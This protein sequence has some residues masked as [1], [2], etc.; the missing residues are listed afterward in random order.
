MAI[1]SDSHLFVDLDGTLIRTDLLFESLLR[2]IRRNPL[3]LLLLPLWL[4]RGRASLKR[5]LARRIALDPAAL[6]YHTE[7]LAW[8]REEHGRGRRMTLITA[9][10]QAHADAVGGHLGLF[11]AALGCG[12][13]GKSP[14]ANLPMQEIPA[15]IFPSG[16]R[17]ARQF[18]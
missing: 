13:F 17:Q 5:Q 18:L 3:Y 15:P 2:L 6:P 7:L 9:S 4:L 8:L 10:D 12:V 11:D 14:A 16:S 1:E